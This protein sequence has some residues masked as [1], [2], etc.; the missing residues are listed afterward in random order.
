[1][2]PSVEELRERQRDLKAQ[3]KKLER[4]RARRAQSIE[5]L[6]KRQQ[7]DLVRLKAKREREQELEKAIEE[8]R[9]KELWTSRACVDYCTTWLGLKLVITTVGAKTAWEAMVNAADRTAHA[10]DCGDKSS[11]AELYSCFANRTAS[12]CPGGCASCNPANPPGH[13]THEGVCDATFAA[14]TKWDD[15]EG[16]PPFAWG[17]DVGDG[18]G[19]V[20]GAKHLGFEVVRPYGDEPWHVNLTAD[21]TPV[22]KEVHAI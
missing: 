16:L 14:I 21:P 22:L 5:D 12:G 19:F 3:R 17:L 6:R 10:D 13:S 18:D 9:R 1:M 8:A 20:A 11:Q 15:G 2:T 4:Q 7:R